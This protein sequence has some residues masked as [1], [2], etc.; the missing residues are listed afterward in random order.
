M[1]VHLL[2]KR[3]ITIDKVYYINIMNML[4]YYYKY[5]N[6]TNEGHYYSIHRNMFNV[7]GMFSK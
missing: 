1:G 4:R 3:F 5:I 6:S 7:G 2:D